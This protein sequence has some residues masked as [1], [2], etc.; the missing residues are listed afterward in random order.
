MRLS[1]FRR[2]SAKGK[3]GSV[4]YEN[5][6]ADWGVMIQAGFAATILACSLWPE[7]AKAQDRMTIEGNTLIYGQKRTSCY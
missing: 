7:M 5:Q 1:C 2:V 3:S 6:Q 4:K